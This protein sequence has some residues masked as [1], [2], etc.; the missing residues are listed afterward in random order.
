MN[1][2]IIIIVIMPGCSFIFLL[3]HFYQF[4]SDMS[5]YYVRFLLNAKPQIK[6]FLLGQIRHEYRQ[7]FRR[8]L[9]LILL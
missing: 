1:R 5:D 6:S 2:Y 4:S 9:T 8:I 7:S 3:I